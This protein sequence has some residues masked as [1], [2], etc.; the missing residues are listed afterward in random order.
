MPTCFFFAHSHTRTSVY[1]CMCGSVSEMLNAVSCH[2]PQGPPGAAGA[3]GRQ[4][5]KG[6]KV[7]KSIHLW[8]SWAIPVPRQSPLTMF[9]PPSALELKAQNTGVI[10]TVPQRELYA[11]KLSAVASS[12]VLRLNFWS[13]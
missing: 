4:G 12:V 5:E 2:S 1:Q 6:A 7:T 11:R 10:S 13:H 8:H 3:E 9:L